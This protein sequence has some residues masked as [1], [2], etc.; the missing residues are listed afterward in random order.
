[1]PT[2]LAASNTTWGSEMSVKDIPGVEVKEIVDEYVLLVYD[3]P[4]TVDG[5]KLRK[6]FLKAAYSIGAMCFTQSCYLLPYSEQSFSL[7]SEV[8]EKGNAVLWV[9]KQ[10]DAEKAKQINFKYE[11]ALKLRCQTIEQRLVIIKNHIEA[12]HLGK[13]NRMAGKTAALLK[14]LVRISETYSPPWLVPQ[15]EKMFL[16]MKQLYQKG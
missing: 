4:A 15:I 11:E 6:Q 10:K 2:V 13:A 14:Q 9:S 8:A 3:I 1:M 16:A 5:N 7:A 12:G